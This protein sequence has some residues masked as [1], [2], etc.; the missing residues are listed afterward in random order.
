MI[1]LVKR[2]IKIDEQPNTLSHQ[3]HIRKQLGFM[4]RQD[5]LYG[6]QFD[7]NFLFYD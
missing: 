3:F 1:P 2:N 5:I 7:D 6:F 4:H